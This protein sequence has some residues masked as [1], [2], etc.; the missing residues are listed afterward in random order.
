MGFQDKDT[1][2]DFIIAPILLNVSL[3]PFEEERDV[4]TVKVQTTEGAGL[5][6][7]RQGHIQRFHLSNHSIE[8]VLV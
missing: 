4:Q 2:K 7:T 6:L 1:F 5:R 3:T 8:C